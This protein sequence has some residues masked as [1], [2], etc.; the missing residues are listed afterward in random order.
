MTLTGINGPVTFNS[1]GN[2]ITLS[3][4]LSGSGGLTVNGSGVLDLTGANSYTGDTTVNAGTLQL[5]AGGTSSSAIRLANGA[6]L[7]LNFAGN[8]VV[9]GFYTNGVALPA[10]V[11]D[12]DIQLLGSGRST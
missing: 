2:T 8:R 4:I 3:G 9:P 10:S 5:D 6:T 12:G 7:N 11:S 1:G